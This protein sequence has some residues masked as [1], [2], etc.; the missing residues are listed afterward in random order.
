MCYWVELG[1]EKK[2]CGGGGMKMSS[3]GKYCEVDSDECVG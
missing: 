1:E 3:E 2:L